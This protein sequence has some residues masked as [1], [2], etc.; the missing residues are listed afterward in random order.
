MIS[1]DQTGLQINNGKH[2]AHS[3]AWQQINHICVDSGMLVIQPENEA[4]IRMPV[5]EIPNLELLLQTIQTG[6]NP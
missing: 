5:V 1:I 6:V 3:L 2:P 4:A